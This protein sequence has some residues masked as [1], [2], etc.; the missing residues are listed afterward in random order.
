[1]PPLLQ[2]QKLLGKG[3]G[4]WKKWSLRCFFGWPEDHDFVEKIVLG[5]PIAQAP[6]YCLLPDTFWLQVSKNAFKV[7]SVKFVNSVSP[8]S[9][10][11]KARTRSKSSQGTKL[12]ELTT[13]PE[14]PNTQHVIWDFQCHAREC[15]LSVWSHCGL[16]LTGFNTQ[17]GVVVLAATNRV[18]ILDPALLRPGRFDRQIYVPSPDI[19]GR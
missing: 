11:K 4:G 6:R 9:I 13:P 17:S 3:D 5:H 10:V 2:L 1:M 18:D 15:I 7:G 19:K 16:L 8:P 14:P 12:R